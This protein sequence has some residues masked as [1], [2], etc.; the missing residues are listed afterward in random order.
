MN[1]LSLNS[2]KVAIF[3]D[4]RVVIAPS[5]RELPNFKSTLIEQSDGSEKFA[6]LL[7]SAE[8]LSSFYR[9]S[10]VEVP[11]NSI[12]EV[13]NATDVF[14]AFAL[15]NP[16]ELVKELTLMKTHPERRQLYSS[17]DT[18]AEIEQLTTICN[19]TEPKLTAQLE[20]YKEML[21]KQ[22]IPLISLFNEIKETIHN[23]YATFLE[24]AEKIKSLL[25]LK[26]E[27]FPA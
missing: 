18:Q 22:S 19:E 27:D 24:A 15:P 16:N 17:P 9:L 12:E 13:I 21:K 6:R 20:D 8:R 10:M 4:S 26:F 25:I 5:P 11:L 7:D 3:N 2:Q 14:R 1:I 23:E